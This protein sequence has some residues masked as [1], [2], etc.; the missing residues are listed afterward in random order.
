MTEKKKS[1]KCQLKVD[2]GLNSQSKSASDGWSHMLDG[3]SWMQMSWM[4]NSAKSLKGGVSPGVIAE[5]RRLRASKQL[6][7]YLPNES[8]KE[9]TDPRESADWQN[10]A[11]I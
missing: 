3:N 1:S 10:Q 9:T 2:L 5:F 8:G 6:L 4:V 11:Q 7:R